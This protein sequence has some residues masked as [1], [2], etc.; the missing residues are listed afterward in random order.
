MVM[1]ELEYP[2]DSAY[3]LKK[4]RSLKKKLLSDGSVRL[5]KKG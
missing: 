2:F 4:K 3:I 1:R 5:K